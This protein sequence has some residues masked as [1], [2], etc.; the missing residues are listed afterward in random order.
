MN[1]LRRFGSLIVFVMLVAVGVVIWSSRE[2][3]R[4][5]W[6]LHTYTPAPAIQQ[7]AADTAMSPYGEQLFLVNKPELNDKEAFNQ[8]CEGMS[9]EAAVLGCY[10][11]NRLGIYLYDVT[12]SRLAGIEQVTAAHEM[13]H[14]A[15]DRLAD[16][17]RTRINKLLEEYYLTRLTSPSVKEKME[18]YKRTE[19]NDLH[20]EMHSIFG[21]EVANLPPELEDY[22]RQY[23]TDRQRVLDF[24]QQ[25]QA[26]FEAYRKQIAQYEEK[27][28]ELKSKIEGNETDLRERAD[29]LRAKKA[30]MDQ[31]LATGDVGAYNAAVAGYNQLVKE[32]N[33]IF[34][35]TKKMIEQYNTIVTERNA[36][37]VQVKSLNEALDSRL[38]PQ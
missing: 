32:Y 27:L 31:D 7:L 22:Y 38:S 6:I 1:F 36:V 29:Q 17:E 35:E 18:V 13:L 19:P 4:D 23:F 8:N 26:A 9:E 24:Y 25:S 3:L 14:Q 2:S 16:S 30:Q 5:W 20:N 28:V 12:D 11:G 21:T 15:Y 33:Q 34:N 10:R 37:A